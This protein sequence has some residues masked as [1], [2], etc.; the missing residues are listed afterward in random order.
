MRLEPNSI[1]TW[2]SFSPG[3]VNANR[4]VLVN[5]HC[6]RRAARRK[7]RSRYQKAC[8]K[9][10]HL[11][12]DLAKLRLL[13]T[14]GRAALAAYFG[15]YALWADATEQNSKVQHDDQV[16]DRLSRAVTARGRCQSP[17]GNHDPDRVRVRLHASD[18][19]QNRRARAV[20]A[21]AI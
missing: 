14:L 5:M 19:E 7:R 9:W 16:A 11:V 18:S 10:D 17:R 15:A 21:H 20:R 3:D 8:H 1:V 12:G 2:S 4:D 6:R 13:T